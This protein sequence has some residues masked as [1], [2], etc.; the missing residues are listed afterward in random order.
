MK[1]RVPEKMCEDT[2][3]VAARYGIDVRTVPRRVAQGLLPKPRYYGTRHP[4]WLISELDANDQ[5]LAYVRQPNAGVLA[6]AK[7]NAAK[8]AKAE[9][10][11]AKKK[12]PAPAEKPRKHAAA[13]EQHEEISF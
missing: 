10:K 8:K 13:V 11:A 5:R 3:G 6:M 2:L 12:P 1:K 9:R 4:R 7:V